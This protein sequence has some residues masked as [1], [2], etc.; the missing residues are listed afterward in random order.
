MAS[1]NNVPDAL[2]AL[3]TAIAAEKPPILTTSPEPSKLEDV[4]QD[5][6]K[7]S[8][9]QFNH[10]GHQ[11]IPLD[12]PTR[13]ESS[14][15]AVDLRSVYLAWLN[16]DTI[17]GEYVSA[18][19]KLNQDL[20][21]ARKKEAVQLPFAEK[22]DLITYLEAAS[23]TSEYIKPLAAEE[24]ARQAAAAADVASGAAGGI[25]AVQTAGQAHGGRH[26]DP[27][28]REIYNGE[29]K[30]GDRNTMLRGIKPTDFSHIRK[31]ASIFTERNKAKHNR[32]GASAATSSGP[33]S[34]SSNSALLANRTKPSKR[35]E[36]IILVSPSASSLLRLSNIKSFLNDGVFQPP[37]ATS[38]EANRLAI[39]RILPAIDASKPL[40]FILVDSPDMFKP[41][42]WSRVAA[43]FTTGQTWQFKSYKWQSPPDLFSHALG[44]YV[45]YRG[46]EIPGVVKSWGRGVFKAE[47]DKYQGPG[48]NRWKDREEV[49]KI[50]KA[51]EDSILAKGMNRDGMLTGRGR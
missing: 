9:L 25:P 31:P 6:A 41:D 21:A 33:T 36:P 37:E 42:Y 16:K 27:R 12:I 46:D 38:A 47:I 32:Q 40:R 11:T 35:V 3:R 19:A 5:L 7:A 10:S 43:V 1:D 28:L 23:D 22:L 29:R 26:I 20:D 34:L 49:E 14:G 15:N 51:I 2:L 24:Q 18:A 17:I 50:W 39:S 8:H 45:G 44:I 4:E 48:Q 13:F 30:M